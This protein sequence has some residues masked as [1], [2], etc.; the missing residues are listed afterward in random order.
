MLHISA[1]RSKADLNVTCADSNE[2]GVVNPNQFKGS[3][4]N[5]INL[6]DV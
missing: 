5:G 2:D 1:I 4:D 3:L 6:S